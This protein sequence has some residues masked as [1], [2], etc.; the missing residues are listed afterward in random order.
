MLIVS[1]RPGPSIPKRRAGDSFGTRCLLVGI[2][3]SNILLGARLTR[4][5]YFCVYVYCSA[6]LA[7]SELRCAKIGVEVALE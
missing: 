6:S 2:R 5:V 3:L 4:L 1:L 7:G